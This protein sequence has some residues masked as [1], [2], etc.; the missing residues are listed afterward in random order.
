[1]PPHYLANA[2]AAHLPSNINLDSLGQLRA[3]AASSILAF[4]P[5]ILFLWL[6]YSLLPVL[7]VDIPDG[8]TISFIMEQDNT[9][10]GNV[11]PGPKVVG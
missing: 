6:H 7:T 11:T 4:L 5:G 2:L 8:I 9:C 1:L 10:A 3:G